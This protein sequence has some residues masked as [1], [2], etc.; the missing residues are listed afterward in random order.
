[1]F[2]LEKV[3][4]GN[5]P[6][7]GISY[8]G[9]DKDRE[10]KEKFSDKEEIKK[11]MKIALKN[12]IRYFACSSQDFNELSPI[13]L[14]SLK[15]LEDE[16]DIRIPLMACAGIPMTLS[17]ERITDYRRWAT[18]LAYEL[19][20]F[21][22]NI[23]ANYY[24]D[25]ILNCRDDWRENFSTAKPYDLKELDRGLKIDWSKWEDEMI[26]FST[27]KIAWIEPGSESDFLALC[28]MDLLEELLDRT[29]EF[30]YRVLLG[31]HHLGITF[32]LLSEERVKKHDGYVA[33]V[34]K[35][36]IMMF[37]TK[38]EVEK[39][40]KNARKEEKIIV[41]VKPFAGGR[42]KPKEALE[43][44]YNEIGV[45]MCMIGTGS[46]EEL[47]EDLEVASTI[48]RDSQVSK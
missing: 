40:I 7:L 14:Q 41:G 21:G 9:K 48:L 12:G 38:K 17:G 6:L 8:Q 36:G 42:I 30:G 47:E 24:E 45:D 25:P 34:N 13:H 18:H 20:Y 39:C 29:H 5:L 37:P 4:F 28:R 26:R 44:V 16:Q 2:K 32:Q 10:Y 43:Y 33:P 31:S 22:K 35:S 11:I 1:M 23:R 46:I 15:E 27:H 19:K 3:I